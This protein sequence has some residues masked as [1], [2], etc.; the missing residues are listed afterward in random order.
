[1]CGWA[2][3]CVLS[4]VMLCGS[5]RVYGDVT[6]CAARVCVYVVRSRGARVRTEARRG[7]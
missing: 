5:V 3:V 7:A 4:D 6:C 1:M 2:C